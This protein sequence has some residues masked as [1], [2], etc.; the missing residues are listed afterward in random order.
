MSN[1]HD[2]D[3]ANAVGATFRADLNTCL[4]DIQ[5][6]NSGSS[7]PST[8]V[9]Y[10][11]WADTANNLLKIRNAS[12]NGWLTLGDL[13]DANNL[14]L[15]TKASPTFSGTVTSAG[16]LVLTGTG[17]LQLPSGTTAQRPTPATGD[18]RFNTSLTQFE[19]YNGTGWG[20]IANGVPAGS[21][22][23]FATT[24]VP[25]GYL[26]CNGAAVSRS[27]YASLFSSISTTWGAGDGSSTFNLPDLRGQFVRGWDNS[28]GVD[29]GRSFAS[30]QSDQ[31]KTHDHSSAAHTHA[32]AFAQGSGGGVGND[33]N[34]TGISSVTQSGG[35]LAELEQGGSADGQDLRGYS[36]NTGSTTPS[37]TGNDGGTEVRVKNK[38]LM[39]VIKF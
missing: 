37:S 13:T 14:G 9:A 6:L 7:D 30:S 26:E 17:S 21:V 39:Y 35:R 24:T 2:Y 19:G 36:A 38:A 23:T 32:Y 31:N 8:T 1:T 5:S 16:D 29:S 25:S 4:G 3:I 28:A 15:A 11:L 20:E 22:F 12:N 33:F 27:T 10:K 18:I 34:S